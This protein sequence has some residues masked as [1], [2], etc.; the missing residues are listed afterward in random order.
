MAEIKI[1]VEG[2]KCERCGYEWVKRKEE[3]PRVCP[4]CHSP[5]WDIPRKQKGRKK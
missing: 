4:K 1:T 3:K 2:Y 5:Y